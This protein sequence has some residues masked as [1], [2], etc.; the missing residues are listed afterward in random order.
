MTSEFDPDQSFT[1]DD[2][3]F[4][5]GVWRIKVT[6]VSDHL[7]R[8]IE[9][10]DELR[11]WLVEELDV[12]SCKQLICDVDLRPARQGR[13]VGT[14]RVYAAFTQQCVVTLEAFDSTVEETIA[15]EFWPASQIDAWDAARGKEAE[16]DEETPDPEPIVEERLEIGRLVHQALVLAV[17]PHPRKPGV[18][19]GSVSTESAEELAAEKPFAALAKLRND[20]H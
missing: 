3:P 20:L 9:A 15:A 8:R 18:E 11:A 16:V 1:L 5:T 19:F 10:S 7:E 2:T 13:I 14:L 6:H 12:L 17:D 4:A